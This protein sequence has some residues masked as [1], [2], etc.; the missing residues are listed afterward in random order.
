MKNQST[1]TAVEFTKSVTKKDCKALL[2]MLYLEL[3]KNFEDENI[4][5]FQRTENETN[6]V[7]INKELRIFFNI[8]EV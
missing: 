5:H 8:S 4:L 1:S 6:I 7:F 2:K 3:K